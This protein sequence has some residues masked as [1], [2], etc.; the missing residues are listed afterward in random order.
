MVHQSCLI[1]QCEVTVLGMII[2]TNCFY[3]K[4]TEPVDPPCLVVPTTNLW[5]FKDSFLPPCQVLR[6]GLAMLV[7]VTFRFP[8]PDIATS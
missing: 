3:D 8:R 6:L 2:V 7:L 5:H 1:V 4:A